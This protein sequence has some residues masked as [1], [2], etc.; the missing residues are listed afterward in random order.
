MIT[1]VF[2]CPFFGELPEWWGKYQ[3]QIPAMEKMGY[4]FLI[5]TDLA[6]FKQR[7]WDKLGVDCPIVWGKAKVHDYRPA[8]GYLYE[9]EIKGFDFWGITDFDVVYGQVDE[10]VT[11]DFLKNLDVHSNHDSYVCGPWS[12]FRNKKEVN[13]LFMK[14][15]D[16]QKFLIEPTVNGWCEMEYSRLLERSG[17]RYAYT[18]WQGFPWDVNPIL[19]REGGELFQ[20]LNGSWEPIMMYH[21]RQIKRWPL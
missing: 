14:Q 18:F 21:F 20:I 5:D 8:L 3:A 12:L 1:K 6:K 2:L 15:I 9:D 16:W 13:E 11:D 17:L 10:W 4:K 19:R 7:V